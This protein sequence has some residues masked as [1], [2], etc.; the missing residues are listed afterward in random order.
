[1]NNTTIIKKDNEK[2][3]LELLG[4]VNNSN[5]YIIKIY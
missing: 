4:E 3:R 1:M 5:R 2:L